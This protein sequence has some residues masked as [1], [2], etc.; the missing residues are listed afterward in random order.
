MNVKVD[1]VANISV[2]HKLNA[3]SVATQIVV[4]NLD[5]VAISNVSKISCAMGTRIMEIYVI[6]IMNAS[7]NFVN[8]IPVTL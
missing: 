6:K 2:V 5:V 1:A 8:K 4:V 7:A 3:K